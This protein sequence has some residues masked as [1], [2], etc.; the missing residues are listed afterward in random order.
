MICYTE[1]YICIFNK[2]NNRIKSLINNENFF[3]DKVWVYS[4]WDDWIGGIGTFLFSK[5][6]QSWV[7]RRIH[8]FIKLRCAARI[9]WEFFAF[10]LV[11]RLSSCSRSLWLGHKDR[12]YTNLLFLIA[13]IF[14]LN[15]RYRYIL[16]QFFLCFCC[17]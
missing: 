7:C 6:Y 2:N 10:D 17:F 11:T 9:N 12:L 14:C 1:L 13:P 15:R 16:F 5:N 8:Q 4:W 3:I